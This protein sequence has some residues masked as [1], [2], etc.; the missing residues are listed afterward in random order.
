MRDRLSSF[1]PPRSVAA[2]AIALCLCG[3]LPAAAADAP[4]VAPGAA[5]R[6]VRDWN[7]EAFERYEA[8]ETARALALFQRAART[9]DASAQ[10]NVA[11]I[12]LRGE[13]RSPALQQAIA[14]L[15]A[16]ARSGFSPAQYM[17]AS[18][19]ETGREVTASQP[20]ASTGA[21]QGGC[22]LGATAWRTAFRRPFDAGT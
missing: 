19:L 21:V 20:E 14:L 10:Y 15:R 2:L 12:R 9:G 1:R 7:R 5:V 13:S 3:A 22:A 8:G 18:M 17:L 16:S 4:A 11:V 6:A